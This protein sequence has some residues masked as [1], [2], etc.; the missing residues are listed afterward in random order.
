[1]TGSQEGNGE[2]IATIQAKEGGDEVGKE[3]DIRSDQR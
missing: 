1:M 2:C 3:G